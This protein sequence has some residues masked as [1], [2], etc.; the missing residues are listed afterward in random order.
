[1]QLEF[2][3][4]QSLE[5]ER[6]EAIGE[7]LK[8]NPSYKA[9]SDYQPVLR[10]ATVPIHVEAHPDYNFLGLVYGS[11]GE[12]QKKLEKETGTRIQICGTKSETKEKVEIT[13][14]DG[15]GLISSCEEVY[16]RISS[17][18][19]EKVDAAAALIELLLSSVPVKPATSTAS[20][21]V[22]GDNA[23][24]LGGVQDVATN[25]ISTS[26][27]NPELQPGAGPMSTSSQ[28]PFPP[29]PRSWLPAGQYNSFTGH[30]PAPSSM[31]FPF[32]P[33][34][35]RPLLGPGPPGRYGF[36]TFGSSQQNAAVPSPSL[37]T[38][39]PVIPGSFMPPAYPFGQSGM[40]NLSANTSTSST[41]S[42]LGGHQPNLAGSPRGSRPQ[43]AERPLMTPSTSPGWAM[44]SAA[45]PQSLPSGSFP[46]LGSS[47]GFMTSQPFS[48]PPTQFSPRLGPAA[49]MSFLPSQ[50]RASPPMPAQ[51]VSLTPQAQLFNPSSNSALR[52]QNPRPPSS[53]PHAPSFTPLK[54][55]GQTA[56][57]PTLQGYGDFTFQPH[58][59]HGAPSQSPPGPGLHFA[60]QRPAL[61]QSPP[62]LQGPSFRHA[63]QNAM[64]Q[65][66]RQNF[67]GAPIGNQMGPRPGQFGPPSPNPHMGPRHLGPVPPVPN[68]GGSFP[69]R[70]GHSAQ[71]P[72]S[73]PAPP[74]SRPGGNF[75]SNMHPNP[76]GRPQVYDPFSPT[77]ISAAQPQG[78]NI[79]IARKHDTDPE[80]EDLMAS[81]GV[82]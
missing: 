27:A 61:V 21:A 80:Y 7:I 31:A 37:H 20:A 29:Y 81:V 26:V 42:P 1:M 43:L 74:L 10:E 66:V 56:P 23:Q 30:A 53:A 69:P 8:L 76:P 54:H 71:Y 52:S 41:Q 13:A 4:L 58:R 79:G 15:S 9:P 70:A 67:T 45:S 63:L 55:M 33:S 62:A 72:Q 46:G 35:T 49:A 75:S 38:S 34:Q 78:S 44:P 24:A 25:A 32:N 17:D 6:R 40:R 50:M 3:K 28:G 19:Y 57:G 11:D 48:V 36:G 68:A 77:S 22:S 2:A 14:S 64:P 39:A 5:L 18:T 16:V 82:K 47:Q 60:S 59:P 73:Y 12:I 51:A 65:P